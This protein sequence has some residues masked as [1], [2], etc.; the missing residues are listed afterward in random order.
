ME[1]LSYIFNAQG[2][3]FCSGAP[4]P[5]ASPSSRDLI[6]LFS[7]QLNAE[8]MEK[9]MPAVRMPILH[10]CNANSVWRTT[11]LNEN[12]MEKMINYKLKTDI[13]RSGPYS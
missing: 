11:E 8:E 9:R 6:Q 7:C 1:M 5:A 13:Y 12:E 2:H 10:E 3:R 4:L